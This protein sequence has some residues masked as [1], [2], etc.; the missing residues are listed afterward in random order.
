MAIAVPWKHRHRI[1]EWCR[2]PRHVRRLSHQKVNIG[3][4]CRLSRRAIRVIWLSDAFLKNIL[5]L[6]PGDATHHF[7]GN[8]ER[9]ETAVTLH[10]PRSEIWTL[11]CD[12]CCQYAHGGSRSNCSV[13]ADMDLAMS[14]RRST[15]SIAAPELYRLVS[16]AASMT[17]TKPPANCEQRSQLQHRCLLTWFATLQ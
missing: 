14:I 15:P 11:T 12:T 2:R 6:L 10:R 16:A 8:G 1:F 13:R 4:S 17:V 9:D 3:R 5:N 7:P